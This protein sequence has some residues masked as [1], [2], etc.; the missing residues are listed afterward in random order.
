MSQFNTSSSN[1][2]VQTAYA[3]TVQ[4]CHNLV[5]AGEFESAIAL[6][7]NA[8]KQSPRDVQVLRMLGHSLMM[9]DESVDSVRYFTFAAKLDPRNPE[10]LCDLASALRRLD[11]L[12]KAH[13][14]VDEVL[15]FSPAHPRA[16]TVKARL[17]QS[18]G[19]SQR[20]F[21]IV[22]AAIDTNFDAGLLGTYGQL[23]RELKHQSKGID[24]MRK[25]LAIVGLPKNNR[26]DIL[27]VLGHLLDSV[28][29]YDEAFDCYSKGN[30]MS[31]QATNTDLVH[32]L[33]R[34]EIEKYNQ[35]PASE[36]DG[37]RAVFI[38]GMP[39]SG[40]TLTEQII[41]SHP[42]AGGVG[43]SQVIDSFT[44]HRDLEAYDQA[45]INNAG[46][47]YLAMLDKNFPDQSIKRVC[48][49]MPENYFFLGFIQ[50]ILPGS[51]I[52]HC[53]RD[54]IDTCLSI[55]FQRFG[56]RLVYA[57]DLEFCAKQ[58]MI[59]TKVMEHVTEK[60]GVTVHDAVYEETTSKPEESIRAI[61]NHI[62][63]P[64]D[65]ACMDFHKSK[66][67]VHTASAT[68]IRQP[69]YTSSTQRWKNYEKHIGP[70]IEA[71]GPLM[72]E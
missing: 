28:G 35:V 4:N 52:I 38:V 10:L 30:A 70:L 64:F 20:A 13:K 5:A 62:G 17:L 18:H 50:R 36:H 59:Y 40:T 45:Y 69:M 25:G 41:A 24:A 37:S 19:Q 39:R 31:A 16:I 53:R 23:C 42:N 34:W 48:D 66:K 71:L 55:F 65:Q 63:L 54:P 1:A 8:L 7:T 43:E 26:Q 21:E 6:L 51:H 12:G 15:K 11:E 56:P 68:Q 58:Y 57:M 72:D 61:L 46:K 60:L 47:G 29:E 33:E 2:P 32:Y 67:S 22:D 44:R 9:I 49:K 14:A 27:F 3:K